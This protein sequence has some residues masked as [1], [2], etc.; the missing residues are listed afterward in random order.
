M[1]E[2]NGIMMRILKGLASR[3]LPCGCVV[4][5]YETYD[6][7]TVAIVDAPGAAC[8][9]PVHQRG[10]TLPTDPLLGQNPSADRK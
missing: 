2:S 10:N 7:H 1:P 5:I 9:D 3:V 4:G 8:T 6:A